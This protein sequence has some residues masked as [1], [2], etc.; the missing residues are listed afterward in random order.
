MAY[1][2]IVFIN[3]LV[4]SREKYLIGEDK[5]ARMAEASSYG[6][7]F[8]TLCEYNFG[9]EAAADCSAEDYE[10]LCDAE[11]EN[12]TAFLKEYAPSEAFLKNLTA[13]NDFFN[14]ECAVRQKNVGASDD[15]FMPEGLYSVASL[16]SAAAGKINV[17]AHLST[18]MNEAQELFDKNEAT[19]AN[20]STLFLRAYYAYMLKNVKNRDW[21]QFV[22][23]EID[24]KNIST[25]LRCGNYEKAEGLFIDGGKL[26]KKTL[27]L[28]CD[29]NEKKALDTTVQT[30]YFDLIKLGFAEKKKGLSLS[31]FEMEVNNFAMKLLKRKRFETDG[32]VPMLLYANYKI[33]EIKNVRL[34]MSLK[35]CGVDKDI[36]KGRLLACYER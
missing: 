1:K 5:F 4:K 11:W 7:A 12:F 22:I 29:G 36:I 25:A 15:A 34:V 16:K 35:L 10:K 21:K 23:Y 3:G 30:P 17:P 18:P 20:I 26:S 33:N 14:A 27:S 24:A 9:G 6:E 28:I 13:R 2:D 32:I 8:K 19:G 31:K